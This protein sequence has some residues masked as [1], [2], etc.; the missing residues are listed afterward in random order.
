M[1]DLMTESA[2]TDTDGRS[3][4][5]AQDTNITL[6]HA[7]HNSAQAGEFP[8]LRHTRRGTGQKDISTQYL[9]MMTKG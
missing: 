2:R 9:M 8:W 5:C 4:H 6:T 3:A 1:L 7:R